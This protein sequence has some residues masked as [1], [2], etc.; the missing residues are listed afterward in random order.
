[1]VIPPKL[2]DVFSGKQKGIT[3]AIPEI[4]PNFKNYKRGHSNSSAHS[5]QITAICQ[6]EK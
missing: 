2:S 5:S 3:S 6:I 1:L 4:I